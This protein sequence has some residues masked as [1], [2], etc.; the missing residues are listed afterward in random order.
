MLTPPERADLAA[1][2]D[3]LADAAEIEE[4]QEALDAYERTEE[5]KTAYETMLAQYPEE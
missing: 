3:D 2:F 1:G 4:W 5:Y